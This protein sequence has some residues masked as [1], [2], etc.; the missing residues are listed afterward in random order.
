[1]VIWEALESSVSALQPGPSAK[2]PNFPRPHTSRQIPGAPA[3]TPREAATPES[4]RRLWC[5][6][7]GLASPWC[8]VI[9]LRHGP[10]CGFL[11]PFPEAWGLLPSG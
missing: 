6:L 8:R 3:A 10:W 5:F 1:M 9:L 4:H 2:V 11:K 7:R